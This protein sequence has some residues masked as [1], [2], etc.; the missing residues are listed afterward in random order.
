MSKVIKF[1]PKKHIYKLENCAGCNIKLKEI[2]FYYEG[3]V[4][5]EEN[6]VIEHIGL[7]SNCHETAKSYGIFS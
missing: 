4:P 2:E 6:R 1:K 5:K 3:K 7:C